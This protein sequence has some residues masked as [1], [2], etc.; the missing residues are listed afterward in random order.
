[1]HYYKNNEMLP[2]CKKEHSLK[3]ENYLS[4]FVTANQKEFARDNLGITDI[5]NSLDKKIDAKVIEFEGIAWDLIPTEGNTEKVLSS[6]AIYKALSLYVTSQEIESIEVGLQKLVNDSSD[7]LDLELNKAIES[8]L[9]KIRCLGQEFAEYTTQIN[10]IIKVFRSGGVFNVS[11]YLQ[12]A[13]S[14]DYAV[15]LTLQNAVN[16]VPNVAKNAGQIITFL[17]IENVWQQYQYQ[18]DTIDDW[19]NLLKWK[20]LNDSSSALIEEG[21]QIYNISEYIPGGAKYGQLIGAGVYTIYGDVTPVSQYR[22]I[23]GW[24]SNLGEVTYPVEKDTSLVIKEVDTDD[25]AYEYYVFVGNDIDGFGYQTTL[26]SNEDEV[27]EWISKAFGDVNSLINV[28]A[29]KLDA[30]KVDKEEGKGLSANDFTDNNVS[31]LADS[32]NN[33]SYDST[34]K[35]LIFTKNDNTTVEV[36]ATDFIKDGMVSN[37]AI[38]NGNL[39]ITFNTDSGKETITIPLTD[40]FDPANYYTKTEI[41]NK[42]VPATMTTLGLVKLYNT[43]GTNKSGLLIQE[44]GSLVVNASANN[45]IYRD[46]VGQLKANIKGSA[47]NE[48][49]EDATSNEKALTPS[50]ISKLK[51]I[52]EEDLAAVAKSGSYNDL[53]GAPEINVSEDKVE[54]ILSLNLPI[55]GYYEENPNCNLFNN[56]YYHIV[57]DYPDYTRWQVNSYNG[58]KLIYRN[59]G[60]LQYLGTGFKIVA[61]TNCTL[62]FNVITYANGFYDGTVYIDGK[63]INSNINQW[64]VKE[65]AAGDELVFLSNAKSATGGTRFICIKEMQVVFTADIPTKTSELTN[66]SKFVTLHNIKNFGEV[67][68]TQNTVVETIT[69]FDASEWEANSSISAT[70]INNSNSYFTINHDGMI[71]NSH[72]ITVDNKLLT[73]YF[74]NSNETIILS[75]LKP[76]T[77][78][79]Y[80]ARSGASGSFPT[81]DNINIPY[82]GI[83]YIKTL[84]IGDTIVLEN[85][86][87]SMGIQQLDFQIY[88]ITIENVLDI[89]GKA[90]KVSNATNGN[91]AALDSNGNLTDSGHKHSDYQASLVSGTNIKTVNGTS[92]LGSGNI[93]TPQGTIT[94]VNMNGSSVATSGVANLGTVITGVKVGT[95][96]LTPSN[97]VVTI[98]RDTTPTSNSSNLITSGGVYSALQNYETKLSF[99]TTTSTSLSASRNIYYRWTS[100]I[101]SSAT[102]YLPTSSLVAGDTCAFNFTTGSSFSSLTWSNGTRKFM[103]D[104][105]IEAGKTYEVVALYDGAKWL[106]TV[107]E[108]E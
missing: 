107:T 8:L 97:G 41:D 24:D 96:S 50:N 4:E 36:D 87:A 102:I 11:Q 88:L 92:I 101:A 60:T 6:D 59:E 58:I 66:D 80:L 86:V 53:V 17:D 78:S 54:K 25:V 47:T 9:D 62:K 2:T 15:K 13:Q 12:Q 42:L 95:T 43:N 98:D 14:L 45:G 75:A 35:K 22:T 85:G 33:V 74:S 38:V 18:S 100:N 104:F 29:N 10:S 30:K 61:D 63:A 16:N 49:I 99:T 81:V 1:M 73:H 39:V 83:K 55:N 105:A 76:C 19:D 106:I 94:G 52:L 56:E 79:L 21:A 108:F 7:A 34:N 103:K 40:I 3:K 46:G 32:I 84:A 90:N 72:D 23:F 57:R 69:L 51:E 70:Q 26:D 28:V 64:F 71:Y 91:F 31:E 37:V 27:P 48:E 65:L 89:T 67:D 93:A 82:T 68:V 77:L 44:D 20:N 5:I